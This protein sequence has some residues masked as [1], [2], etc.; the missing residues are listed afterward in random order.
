MYNIVI[1]RNFS[2]YMG[3]S[4]T[5]RIFSLPGFGCQKML[6]CLVANPVG[7]LDKDFVSV[8]IKLL[9]AD[10]KQASVKFK[11]CIVNS[12]G[13]QTNVMERLPYKFVEGSQCGF[14]KFIRRDIL[15]NEASGLLPDDTL[16][17]ICEAHIVSV[18]HVWKIENFSFREE[19]A[20]MSHP[21]S[22][23][24]PGCGNIKWYVLA[25]LRCIM[26]NPRG[27]ED[28]D[29]DFVSI[30]LGLVFGDNKQTWAN[31]NFSI[32]S[33]QRIET[34]VMIKNPPE[35]TEQATCRISLVQGSQYRV[36]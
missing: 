16:T 12:I 18:G 26:I 3:T 24:V 5:S 30:H 33:A 20:L 23:P 19:K 2:R 29:R 35:V 9:F 28:E 7:V 6:W 17:V 32:L 34:N 8:S 13:E 31:M 14:K 25:F 11:F 27:A 36:S 15:L 1:V 4:L 21:F 22:T 10:S